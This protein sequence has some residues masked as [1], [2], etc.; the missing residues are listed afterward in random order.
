L[1]RLGLC[2]EYTSGILGAFSVT[3]FQAAQRVSERRVAWLFKNGGYIIT[4][5]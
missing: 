2:S 5:V 3:S 4:F 1:V